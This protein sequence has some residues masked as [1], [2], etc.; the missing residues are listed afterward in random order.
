[1]LKTAFFGSGGF[2]AFCLERLSQRLKPQ[3]VVTNE[4]KPAGRGMEL[5]PTPVQLCA[6]RLAIPFRTT[7]KLS[8]DTELISWIKAN[9]PDVL[10]VIDFGHIVKEPLLSL[11]RLGCLNAHPS[12]LP[13]Y[14]GSAPVQR[15]IMDGLEETAVTLFRLDAGMDSGP[16]LAQL[17]VK[18][19]KSDNTGTLLQKCAE[20][21][22]DALAYYLCDLPDSEWKFKPQPTEGISLAPKIE[23]SEGLLDWREPASKLSCLVRG[24]GAAPG[25]FCLTR[26]KRLRVHEAAPVDGPS[27]EA[28]AIVAFA[29]GFPVV[30]CGT[31]ALV[32]LKVQP[33]GKKVQSAAE[34]LRG[35]RLS[36]G[37]KL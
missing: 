1:M 26:G 19:E 32:L 8:S 10:L 18:I 17:P 20:V 33:E 28:G 29:D 36:V 21:G 16:V 12:R 31:G 22:T 7:V 4:P 9:V 25:T 2:A 15:A 37:D 14:R 35:S 13:Q 5:R 30:A 11:A 6:E 24:I 23:K 27:G 34:W 3:W